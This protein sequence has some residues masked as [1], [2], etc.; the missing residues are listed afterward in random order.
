MKGA[1]FTF[2]FISVRINP[3]WTQLT[4]IG[5]S[6]TSIR[7]PS[8]NDVSAA[9]V[10]AYT[11]NARRNPR[12]ALT[13]EIVTRCPVFCSLKIS[14][15]ASHCAIAAI[16]LVCAVCRLALKK[17][18]PRE[19]PLPNPAL[20]I[21]RSRVANSALNHSVLCAKTD[22]ILQKSLFPSPHY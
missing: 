11:V 10:A 18:V 12:T 4:F 17:P 16:K 6:I 21:I 9:L 20:T 14:S 8:V 19:P 2:S 22:M 1:V 13:E 5:V 7:I 15:A 3:G